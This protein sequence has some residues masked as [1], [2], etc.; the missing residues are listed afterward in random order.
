MV[1][2]DSICQDCLDNGR[3]TVAYIVFYQGGIIDHCTH[4]PDPV[5]QSIAIS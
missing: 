4:F 1:F 3:S 2:S 5:A